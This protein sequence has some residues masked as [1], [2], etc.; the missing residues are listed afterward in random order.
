[1]QPKIRLFFGC[2][3]RDLQ[4]TPLP[5]HSCPGRS[6]NPLKQYE[7]VDPQFIP[8]IAVSQV[9]S[10]G[11]HRRIDLFPQIQWMS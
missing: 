4:R 11:S 9:R 6:E 1:L 10:L 2:G 3:S 8:R 5:L 7:R